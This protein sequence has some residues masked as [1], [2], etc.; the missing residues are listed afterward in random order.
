MADSD[1]PAGRAGP[2]RAGSAG[3]AGDRAA[4]D[5]RA[6]M[7]AEI[8]DAVR[9]PLLLVLFL[10][11]LVLPVA[12][13]VAGMRLT[14][15]R[16]FLLVTFVP[17]ALKVISGG[18][19]RVRLADAV[20]VVFGAWMML[21]IIRAE[22]MSRLPYSAILAVEIMGG[23]FLGRLLIR[24]PADWKRFI[25]LHF[26]VLLV[27]APFVAVELFTG[28]QI[29]AELLDPI[30]EV[31]WRPRSSRPRMG[32]ERVLTGFDHPILYG[33]FCS[34][35]AAATFYIWRDRFFY[36]V[37]RVGFMTGMTFASLSSGPLL[38]VMI[39]AMLVGWDMVTRGAWKTIVAIVA[40]I[41]I[42]LT[43]ASN[44]GPVI[45]FIETMTFSANNAWTRV[46]QWRY[47][48]ENVMDHKLYGIGLLPWEGPTWLGQSIDAFWLA[49]AIR[50]GLV[51]MLLIFAALVLVLWGTLRRR[52]LD[53]LVAR[54]R[55]GWMIGF[56]GLFFTL[57]TVHVWDA[58]SVVVMFYVG[59]GVWYADWA[60]RDAATAGT[61]AGTDGGTDGGTDEGPADGGGRM[62]PRTSART[63]T[64][65]RTPP[66]PDRQTAPRTE[67]TPEA[68][69]DPA[70]DRAPAGGSRYARDLRPRH[71]R[72]RTT[73]PRPGTPP[74]RE[75]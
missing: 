2:A 54:Y 29:W 20:F 6:Q 12:I 26:I 27:L 3:A 14:P 28:R 37:A 1:F 72:E 66:R 52:D 63:Q 64:G 45:I 47:G 23:Y 68:A 17:V 59:A 50:H 40:T 51:G 58:I 11:A 36:A 60:G 4:S 31:Q 13:E 10:V 19:G 67:A 71:T 30:G 48:W 70:A 65:P 74:R 33:L 38:S 39:Q 7:G 46:N 25:V 15:I 22:G 42:F 55:T 8:A 24:S 73:R 34:L 5:V 61:A 35:G 9:A 16:I 49:I 44:R 21:T 43:V 56:T 41:W 57:T 75:R 32:L 62:A 69:P 53:P 18:A